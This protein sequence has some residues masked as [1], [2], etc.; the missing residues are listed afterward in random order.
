[1]QHSPVLYPHQSKTSFLSLHLFHHRPPLYG[2]T[3]FKED[4]QSTN[5][6]YKSLQS[7]LNTLTHTH[8]YSIFLPSSHVRDK[9][10]SNSTETREE[11]APTGPRSSVENQEHQTA[12]KGGEDRRRSRKGGRG[13]IEEEEEESHTSNTQSR[14]SSFS[15]SQQAV[16]IGLKQKTQRAAEMAPTTGSEF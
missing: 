12:G 11:S 13:V 6:L 3:V 4:H 1:M 8:T 14:A 16:K 9:G 7:Y 10:H 5:T 2:Q 15:V